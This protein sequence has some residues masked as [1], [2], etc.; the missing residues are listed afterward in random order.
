M[1]EST[2]LELSD[3]AIFNDMTSIPN[4]VRI[5]EFLQSLMRGETDRHKENYYDVFALTFGLYPPYAPFLVV[6]LETSLLTSL[7]SYKL[8]FLLH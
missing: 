8:F 5:Y 1:V 3:E 4:F 7:L 2:G 6:K